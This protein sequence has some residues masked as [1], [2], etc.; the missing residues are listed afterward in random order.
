MSQP[1]TTLRKTDRQFIASLLQLE[2]SPLE[3]G[4]VHETTSLLFYH[5]LT[6]RTT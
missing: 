3:R 5:S 1:T 6:A 4:S 2:S